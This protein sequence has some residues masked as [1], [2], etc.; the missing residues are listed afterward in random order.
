MMDYPKI[1]MGKQ[2]EET[3]EWGKH[4]P[5]S[6]FRR[7]LCVDAARYPVIAEGDDGHAEYLLADGRH[8]KLD[9]L[10][11]IREV[12]PK[13]DEFPPI[14]MGVEYRTVHDKRPGRVLCMDGKGDPERP[15]R[16]EDAD[17]TIH[18]LYPNGKRWRDNT[19]PY[20]ERVPEKIELPVKIYQH[21]CNGM[22][23]IVDQMPLDAWELVAKTTIMVQKG[24]G[25]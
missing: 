12:K 20:I 21:K 14:E 4:F 1:E 6:H 2:Y 9:A 25:L 16:F 5:K 3:E 17:G 24:E 22:H 8:S 13:A 10:P 23:Y 18:N 15:V 19:K 11:V 7:V